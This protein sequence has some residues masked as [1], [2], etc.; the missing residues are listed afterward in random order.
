MLAD[1]VVGLSGGKAD[2]VI[3]ALNKT[4]EDL[5]HRVVP[6]L[7]RLEDDKS[8][9]VLIK[10]AAHRSEKVRVEALR[11]I[12]ARDLWAPEK[13]GPPTNDKSEII[14]ELL[15]EYPKLFLWP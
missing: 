4:D 14:R 15:V 9:E 10:L 8:S 5:L 11:A 12:M 13:I 1:V 6:I 7:G 2:R 3:E